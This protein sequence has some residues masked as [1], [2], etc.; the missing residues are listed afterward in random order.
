M[1]RTESRRRRGRRVTAQT[2]AASRGADV[3]GAS[4]NGAPVPRLSFRMS[5]GLI[6]HEKPKSMSLRRP[7]AADVTRR[8]VWDAVPGGIPCRVEY[9]GIREKTMPGGIPCR[10]EYH[11]I[12]DKTMPGGIPSSSFLLSAKMKFSGLM[13]RWTIPHEWQYSTACHEIHRKAISGGREHTSLSLRARPPARPPAR[14]RPVVCLSI[15]ALER[16]ASGRMVYIPYPYWTQLAAVRFR[17]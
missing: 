17:R 11:G 10:V 8:A 5:P 6:V 2:W 13:S 9:H 3:G 14:P 16:A 15:A 1:R 12:R 4:R 7:P